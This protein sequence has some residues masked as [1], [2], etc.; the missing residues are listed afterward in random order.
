MHTVSYDLISIGMKVLYKTFPEGMLSGMI[1]G[2]CKT[3]P[4]GSGRTKSLTFSMSARGDVVHRSDTFTP[5]DLA[6]IQ[7]MLDDALLSS[8]YK[9]DIDAVH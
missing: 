7:D 4:A 5:G 2:G 6:G 3:T 8:K 9:Y 1:P